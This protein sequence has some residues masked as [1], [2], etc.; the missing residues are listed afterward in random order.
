MISY[1][2]DILSYSFKIILGQI[3]AIALNWY[4]NIGLNVHFP[5]FITADVTVETKQ[6]GDILVVPFIINVNQSVK[7]EGNQW[8]CMTTKFQYLQKTDVVNKFT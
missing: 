2:Y 3:Y 5:I 7:N 1:I 6:H 4:S 8:L